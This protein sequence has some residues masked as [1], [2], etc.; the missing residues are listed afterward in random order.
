MD[1]LCELWWMFTIKGLVS[2][3]FALTCYFFSY[4]VALRL[5]KPIGFLYLLVVFT[6]YICLFGIILLVGA[7][8]A[9]DA[10]L[11]HRWLLLIDGV[12]NLAIGPAFLMT[13]GFGLKFSMV[14]VLFAVHAMIL[15][16]VYC[17]IALHADKGEC[18]RLYLGVTGM[19]SIAAGVLLIVFQHKPER[20]LTGGV[21]IYTGILGLLL[22]L[23][24]AK[25][26]RTH[27]MLK[28]TTSLAT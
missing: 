10:R 21:A 18:R 5:L 7:L 17:I 20:A 23:L 2:V 19:W 3:A 25:L 6:F 22:L 27:R 24:S 12:L 14:V 4:V 1:E 11:Q 13:F 9:F 26:R 16:A 28:A 15:G 8:Y